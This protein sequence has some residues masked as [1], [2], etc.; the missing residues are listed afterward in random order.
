MLSP[1]LSM[2][3]SNLCCATQPAPL[4]FA[5]PDQDTLGY[6]HSVETTGT[7]DGPG[8]RYIVF[9]T[10]CP[11][12][13][14]YCHNPD[15]ARLKNGNQKTTEEIL[16][17]LAKYK[18]FIIPSGGGLTISGGEPLVQAPFATT[19]FQGA[20]EMGMHTALDTAGSLPDRITPQLLEAVDLVLLDIKSFDAA[21]YHEVTSYEL[22]PTLRTA[23][24]L[25]E[26]KKPV[27][28]RYVVV[29]NLTDDQKHIRELAK[30]AADLGVV[31]RVECLPFHKMGEYKW[32][33][34]GMEYKLSDTQP[35]EDDAMQ[36][37]REI[38]AA[39]GLDAR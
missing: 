35:P 16:E 25:S 9:L 37:I 8:L 21:T 24:I 22:A 1:V 39:E 17:D 11:M 12:R 7:L 20:K 10:G 34:L 36:E 26:H 30:F 31:E 28:L 18:N 33:E 4:E 15:T 19:L 5:L 3:T 13:C 32:K 6:V 14:Q 29:P 2:S 38:F 23:K 27:W